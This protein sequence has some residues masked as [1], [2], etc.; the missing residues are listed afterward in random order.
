MNVLGALDPKN[1]I[2]QYDLLPRYEKFLATDRFFLEQCGAP[3][4]SSPHLLMVGSGPLP[5]SSYVFVSRFG[6]KVTNVDTSSEALETGKEILEHAGIFQAH[7]HASGAEVQVG[8]NVTSVI[9]AA[10]A[11]TN[12]EEKLAIIKNIAGQLQPGG[13][14][15]VRYGTGIRKLFYPDCVLSDAECEEYGIRRIGSFEPPRDYMNAIGVYE[16][17]T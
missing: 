11:G 3:E 14:I 7:Q 1:E 6:Y 15:S 5:I 10:L 9:V 17:C 8:A 16:K 4:L 13:R 2:E 12:K